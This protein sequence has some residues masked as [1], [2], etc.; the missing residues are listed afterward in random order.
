MIKAFNHFIEEQKLCNYDDNILVAVSGGCDSVVLL[1]LLY[2]SE[3]K[4][5]VAHCNFKL[6]GVESDEDEKFVASLAKGY[7]VPYFAKS[8]DTKKYAS[9]N[10]LSVQ[11]AARD[12]RYQWFEKLSD[13]H[14]LDKVA[15]AHHL[16]DQAETFFINLS[17]G[18]GL[19][20]LKGM[21]IKRGKI[22]RPLLFARREEVEAY[23]DSNSLEYRTDSSNASV[24]YLRNKIRHEL[25]PVLKK[26]KPGFQEQLEKSLQFLAEDNE[27]FQQMIDDK[28]KKIIH[29]ESNYEWIIKS[30]LVG[31]HPALFFHILETYG[32][33]RSVTD[34]LLSALNRDSTGKV[35]ES[36]SHRLLIDR[37][38]VIIQPN[39][40]QNKWKGELSIIESIQDP[41][42]LQLS[43]MGIDDFTLDKDNKI[44][45]FDADLLKLPLTLRL[46]QTGDYFVPFGMS[47]KKLVSDLLIDIKLNRFEK[48]QVWV[49]LSGNE[50]IWVVGY[51]AT[52]TFKI[53]KN[54]RNVLQLTVK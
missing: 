5:S 31:L 27:V 41:I 50:I 2:K 15:I 36:A 9:E 33:N 26:L 47:G 43:N 51:R 54:T 42:E 7:G 34:D 8:F 10:G 21:P 38:R 24:K 1:D 18:S 19:K 46:W 23:A 25:M 11:E 6:R 16:D 39:V 44:A 13:E 53:G 32:F 22:I 12:L 35:F 45:A 40:L 4:I 20:G 49:L 17:R 48:E 52:N 28:K 30:D 14:S 3:F 37:D 29:P